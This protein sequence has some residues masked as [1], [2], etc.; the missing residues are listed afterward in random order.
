MRIAGPTALLG[1]HNKTIM[2]SAQTKISVQQV[3]R[4][5]QPASMRL[6]ARIKDSQIAAIRIQSVLKLHVT[7]LKDQA[8]EYH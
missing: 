7:Q 6:C 5:H 3:S 1:C 4:A 8:R 2:T